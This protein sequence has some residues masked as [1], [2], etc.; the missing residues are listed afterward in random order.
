MKLFGSPHNGINRAGL[1]TEGAT[2]TAFRINYCD[3]SG[4]LDTTAR[5]YLRIEYKSI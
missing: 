2:N 3:G 5:I 1:N 4:A